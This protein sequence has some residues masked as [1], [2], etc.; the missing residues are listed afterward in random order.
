MHPKVSSPSPPL[1]PPWQVPRYTGIV[2][3][4]VRVSSEQGVASFWR[5]NLANVIR[6]F[7][8]QVRLLLLLALPG[9]SRLRVMGACCGWCCL[10]FQGCCYVGCG[11]W[12]QLLLGSCRLQCLAGLCARTAAVGWPRALPPVMQSATNQYTPH[13]DAPPTPSRPYHPGQAF[14]FAFKD[15]I[16]GIFPKY[17]PKTDFW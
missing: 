15:T 1:V 11:R 6:Y 10:P 7:P 8:T 14:N 2:N 4:F 16:K 9:M 12:W 3:C 13:V 17:S 5:G